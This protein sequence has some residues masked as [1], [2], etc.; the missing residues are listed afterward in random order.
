MNDMICMWCVSR[1]IKQFNRY[2]N[3]YTVASYKVYTNLFKF[4]WE[5][6]NFAYVIHAQI[7]SWN[8]QVLSNKGIVSCFRKQW[9]PLMGLL[10]HDW[11]ASII[12]K[13]DCATHCTI[14]HYTT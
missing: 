7:H 4:D 10:T 13:S 5:T 9:E 11:Q 2:T 1:N 8:Q 14:P 12:Y 3:M 6:S